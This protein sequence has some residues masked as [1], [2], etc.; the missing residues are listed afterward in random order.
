MAGESDGSCRQVRLG[1]PVDGEFGRLPTDLFGVPDKRTDAQSGGEFAFVEGNESQLPVILQPVPTQA[2]RCTEGAT[3]PSQGGY[4]A[5]PKVEQ[6]IACLFLA[7]VVLTALPLVFVYVVGR[8]QLV[9]GLTAGFS[10]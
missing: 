6:L 7:A 2:L 3:L 9:A 1:N 4:S 10:K 5:V 8:R